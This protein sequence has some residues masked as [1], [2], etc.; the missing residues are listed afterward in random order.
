MRFKKEKKTTPKVTPKRI[1]RSRLKD[2]A[3]ILDTGGE[4]QP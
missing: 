1:T 3:W 2:L 4:K